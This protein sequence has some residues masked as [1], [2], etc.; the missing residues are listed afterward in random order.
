MEI[1]YSENITELKKSVTVRH[2]IIRT[3]ILTISIIIVLCLSV[4]AYVYQLSLP[5][6]E[7]P[8]EERITIEEGSAIADISHQFAEAGF[9][10]SENLLY[11]ALVT[12][13]DPTAIKASTYRFK[14]PLSTFEIAFRLTEGDFGI[15]LIRF[16]HYEGERAKHIAER[17]DGLL[18]DFDPEKFIAL[19]ESKEGRLF[20]DTYLIPETFT[21]KELIAL[22]EEAYESKVAPLRP[23]IELSQFTED[24]VI[25]F[26]SIL[27]RE[28]NS[29]ESKRMVSGI[30]YNRLE[31]DM[32]L[33][34]DAVF[35]FILDKSGTALTKDD[36]AVESPYNTYL[37]TG[38]PPGPIGNP[39]L[40][41]IEAVLEPT[42]SSYFFYITGYDGNFYYANT[43]QQHSLNV[44]RYLR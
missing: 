41:A 20:P 29:R 31:I 25:V 21:E 13:H 10:R 42:P 18:L 39:G 36:L 24:E 19:A 22:M 26:A 16:V 37:N 40:T 14:K 30:I 43:Y 32:A 2:R 4:S 15:D 34:V 7:F 44:A 9:V 27:E 8:S 28:A 1:H 38:L 17:A 5:P 11:L 3:L 6:L 12:L 35:E 33:Q 23:A